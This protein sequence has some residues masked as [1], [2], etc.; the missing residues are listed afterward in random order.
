MDFPLTT[1]KTIH[2]ELGAGHLF[3]LHDP[4]LSLLEMQI[5]PSQLAGV[6]EMLEF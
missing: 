1:K 6:R 3:C 5:F 2:Q 4:A